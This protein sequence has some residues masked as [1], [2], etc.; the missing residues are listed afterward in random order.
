MTLQVETIGRRARMAGMTLQV[1]DNEEELE[2]DM[3]CHI[4]IW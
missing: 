1:G 2:L 4:V 3:F